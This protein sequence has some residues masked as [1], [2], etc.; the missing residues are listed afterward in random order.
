MRSSSRPAEVGASTQ[1][2]SG[3][4]LRSR[5]ALWA[6]AFLAVPFGLFLLIRIYPAFQALYLS[7]FDWNADP[8][9]RPFVGLDHYVR[10]AADAR[11]GRALLNTGLY[12]L[13]GV[14]V[15]LAL[16]LFFA[17]VMRGVERFRA[18]FRA[19][20]FAPYVVP[21]VAIGWV[22]SW[23]LSPNFGVVNTVLTAVG[24]PAQGFLGD[25]QQAL[26]TVTAVVIWQHLG[27]QIVLFLAGLESIPRTFYEA[28]EIDGA[29]PWVRFRS[30][31]VPLLNP[32]IVF[33]A[34]I[35]AIRYL[36]LFTLVVNLHFTDQ[37]GPLNSTLSVALYIYQLAFN[38][39]QFGY[40]AAV[41]V[42]M[43]VIVMVV[44]LVQ[45]RLL[46]RRVEY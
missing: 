19:V 6:Y 33:S 29:G 32:V 28:A 20:F 22:F 11:L 16:G 13:I 5:E 30:I 14:P 3:L 23:M 17:V 7:L 21:A 18:F 42:I 35:F 26:P 8:A 15:Q 44:T 2:A 40:A 46:S 31:T 39:F 1:G 4:S 27:F 38:R 34:V 9:K 12:T 36:Q 24:L 25:P 43:F 10:A 37:G 45:M 41:T